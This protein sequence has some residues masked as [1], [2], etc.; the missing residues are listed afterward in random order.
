LVI[1]DA[2][3][4]QT[5]HGPVEHIARKDGES[6]D[7]HFMYAPQ[8][9]GQYRLTLRAAAQA[10][11][12]V[13]KNNEMT[14]FLT[15][16]DGGLKVLYLE[17]EARHEYTFLR[18]A[19]RGA[20]D[21]QLDDVWIDHNKRDRWP[22]D[23]TEQFSDPAIDVFILGSVAADA[24]SEAS[25]DALVAAVE[26]SQGRD[27]KGLLLI[28]GRYSYGPGRW[29]TTKLAD[30][31]PMTIEAREAQD[32]DAALRADRHW[33][34]P[35]AMRPARGAPA[36]GRFIVELAPDADE[37]LA[38]WQSLKPLTGANR[39]DN[40]RPQAIVLAEATDG[41]PLVVARNFGDGRVLALAGDST[42]QWAMQGQRDAHARFW[43]QA[44]LWLA[45]RD[46]D[47]RDDVWI[48]LDQRR[49]NPGGRVEFTTG[50][51]RS[52]GAAMAG[53]S[54]TA[55]VTLPDGKKQAAR[56]VPEAGQ[57]LGL[58][59]ET[60]QP[61]NYTIEVRAAGIDR[62]AVTRF[63][64]LDEDLEL[65]SP[66]ANP[67]ALAAM[68]EVTKQFGGRRVA[69]EEAVAILEAIKNSPPNL[70]EEVQQR[71]ELGRSAVTAWLFFLAMTALMGGEWFLRKKWGLI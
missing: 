8:E 45:K 10:G 61:G 14:A 35:L 67:E 56:L 70:R 22:L 63:V 60:Q 4:K 34:K 16:R 54:L 15:V 31:L 38:L 36:Q 68:A 13:T 23:F 50:V 6:L 33:Q 26:G 41:T 52:D 20:E 48:D 19:L 51:K 9:K 71:F 5:T 59:K 18:R 28:G 25:I 30:L 42:Y 46:T 44:V 37:N 69:P 24:L 58:F 62:P 55:E 11:E 1:E 57:F 40:L 12:L 43:R 7:I 21:I 65:G 29:A 17:G 47:R 64:V 32:F 3:G 49:F 27:G 53:A 39:F 2:S 66:S